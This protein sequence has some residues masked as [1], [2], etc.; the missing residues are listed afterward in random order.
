M[1][2]V[3]NENIYNELN[4]WNFGAMLCPFL[5]GLGNKIDWTLTAVA[6]FSLCNPLTALLVCIW[7]GMNGNK[8]ALES[9]CYKDFDSFSKQQK[10]WT[11][12]ILVLYCILY[13]VFA[14]VYV[15]M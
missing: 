2:S 12:G 9:G 6:L 15:V 10:R 3:Y 1:N 7:F 8:W 13:L 11:A 14:V 4:N 5:W